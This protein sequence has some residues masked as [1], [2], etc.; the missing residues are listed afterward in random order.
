MRADLQHKG[1]LIAIDQHG[2]DLEQMARSLAL[3]PQLAATARMEV[4]K[5]S[6]A[7]GVERLLVHEGEHEHFAGGLVLH[8]GPGESLGVEPWQEGS[9]TLSV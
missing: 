4:R 6:G 1:I 5:A 2:L 8:D 9:S 7:G 3:L